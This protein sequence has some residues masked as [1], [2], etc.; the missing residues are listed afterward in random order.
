MKLTY[1]HLQHN[2]LEEHPRTIRIEDCG[3]FELNMH[4]LFQGLLKPWLA[5]VF[6]SSEKLGPVLSQDIL[7]STRRLRQNSRNLL[8]S[9]PVITVSPSLGHLLWE[10]W[11]LD[12]GICF[13]NSG[14]LMLVCTFNFVVTLILNI[15]HYFKLQKVR[16]IS[17]CDPVPDPGYI[18]STYPWSICVRLI[19]GLNNKPLHLI[20]P[21]FQT[22]GFEHRWCLEEG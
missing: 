4:S 7:S 11:V 18:G 3:I 14:F 17:D 13:E 6:S 8:T 12:V 22:I 21:E 5:G 19:L 15:K 9:L 16:I 2:Y 20:E 1:P 10:F